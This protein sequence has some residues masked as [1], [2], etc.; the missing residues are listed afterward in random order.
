MLCVKE[1]LVL[2]EMVNSY[3]EKLCIEKGTTSIA[4]EDLRAHA[5]EK[6]AARKKFMEVGIAMLNIRISKHPSTS[7]QKELLKIETG[8]EIKGADLKEWYVSPGLI[9]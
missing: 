5:V 3:S 9:F 1:L 8:L 6:L 4:L 2:Q 7:K